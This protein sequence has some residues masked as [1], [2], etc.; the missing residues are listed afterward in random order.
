MK[1]LIKWFGIAVFTAAI[2]FGCSDGN[3]DNS[4]NQAPSAGDFTIDGTGTFT[5]NGSPRTVTV[6]AKAG[7][8]TGAVT[9][10]YNG[11]ATAPTGDSTT[12]NI[13]VVTFDVTAATGWNAVSG[14]SAGVLVINPVGG[15]N[16]P[17]TP[18]GVNA[19]ANSAWSITVSWTAV[20]GATNGYTIYRSTSE[21]GE[22]TQVATPTTTSYVNTGL[23]PNTTY[24]YKV[25]AKNI[26]GESTHSA[27]VSAT[28]NAT[29]DGW[30]NN[31]TFIIT[32]T[33]EWNSAIADITGQTGE[34]TLTISD[35]KGDIGV[36]GG[37]NTF[38]TTASG[39]LSVTLNGEGKLYLTSQGN[40]IRIG[41]NQTLIIDS[42]DLTLEGLTDGE[43]DATQDNNTPVVFVTTGGTLELKKGT[44][45]GNTSGGLG[46]G[47]IV[48]SGT[49]TMYGG[50]ISNN[51]T[52]GS[53][54]GV[55]VFSDGTFT[56]YGGEISG[57]TANNG[58]GVYVNSGTLRIV[59]GTIYG[60]N[61]LNESLR[62]TANSGASLYN[63]ST[64][65]RGTFSGANGAW[66]SKG[67]LDSTDDTINVE[68][69]EFV[70]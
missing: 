54:G 41:A 39:S 67:N 22:Y 28:T 2:V 36:A 26:Y 12:A 34:Y 61:E 37:N 64:A 58:G 30:G 8:T 53:G 40:L 35:E 47:V 38:G 6:T 51:T 21:S 48:Y 17:D 10:K 46:G 62:N 56:M 7:K 4:G 44:I 29:T 33:E 15:T 31:N 14:L 32:N 13:Y 52:S 69:G 60:S 23:T 57:N 42:E 27:P 25:S 65:Q 20:S 5:Y 49:F 16:P 63:Y 66:V 50:E 24:Y 45:S 55:S 70:Q 3:N 59:T 68:D 43:N 9:V 18:T 11:N 1:N 19:A